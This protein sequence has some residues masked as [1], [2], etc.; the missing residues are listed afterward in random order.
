MIAP[1][2]AVS[3]TSSGVA[4]LPVV[5]TI[6]GLPLVEENTRS[7]LV[8]ICAGGAVSVGASPLT[9]ILV[10]A[11][12]VCGPP[13]PLAPRSFA[14]ICRLTVPGV[15]SARRETQAIESIV[16]ILDR[17]LEGHGAAAVRA[18]HERQS[19]DAAQR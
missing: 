9:V 1:F 3:V 16:D 15:V 10:T 8:L 18:A 4:V 12:A 11:V 19:A 5:P 14:M 6:I 2:V 13:T 7:T 17:S